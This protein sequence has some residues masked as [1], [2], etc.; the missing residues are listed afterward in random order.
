[1]PYI[2]NN[3][4]WGLFSMLEVLLG[5]AWV[6]CVAGVHFQAHEG[7]ETASKCKNFSGRDETKKN[8]SMIPSPPPLILLCSPLPSSNFFLTLGTPVVSLNLP[9]WKMEGKH[10]QLR[11][12][13]R[14][15]YTLDLAWEQTRG[16]KSL[17]TS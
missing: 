6:A 11:L 14:T 13:Y 12:L 17:F 2:N 10:L 7:N 4:Y 5:S 15:F 8:L 16:L 1:M 9:T 3:F